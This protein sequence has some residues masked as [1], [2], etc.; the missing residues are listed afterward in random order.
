MSCALWEPAG[1]SPFFHGVARLYAAPRPLAS[2][3]AEAPRLA[4]RSH[5]V[6]RSAHGPYLPTVVA[7]DVW[8]LEAALAAAVGCGHRVSEAVRLALMLGHA[9]LASLAD[10]DP[11]RQANEDEGEQASDE[12]LAVTSQ[13]SATGCRMHPRRR[14]RRADN[15]YV[16]PARLQGFG[17]H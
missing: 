13:P 2:R 3:T 4:G 14:Q 12:H 10:H 6:A 7:R 16:S 8:S 11:E 5:S 17:D 1:R 15:L 9:W